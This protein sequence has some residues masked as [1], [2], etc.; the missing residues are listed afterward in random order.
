M[1]R[2]E[3]N[4]GEHRHT[5]KRLRILWDLVSGKAKVVEWRCP[6]DGATE[7][8]SSTSH[9]SSTKSTNALWLTDSQES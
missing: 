9:L 7:R 2:T 3:R 8:T 1:F 4:L 5:C 6:R